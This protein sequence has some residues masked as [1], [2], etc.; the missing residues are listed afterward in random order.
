[1]P[2]VTRPGKSKLDVREGALYYGPGLYSSLALD[3]NDRPHI[4]YIDTENME[5]E[6]KILGNPDG[7]LDR[8]CRFIHFDGSGWGGPSA[9]KLLGF[10]SF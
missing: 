10:K 3:E 9:H 2:A 1:M 6:R 8:R 7:G 4:S 5:L